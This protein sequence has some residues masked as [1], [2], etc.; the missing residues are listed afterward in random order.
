MKALSA[1]YVLPLTCMSYRNSLHF[2]DLILP[3]TLSSVKP[4]KWDLSK[5]NAF[6]I[7]RLA[8]CV[9]R[10]TSKQPD[11]QLYA[12]L[13]LCECHILGNPP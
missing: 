4:S 12:A 5:I 2:M 1:R 11:I 9:Q 3:N 7:Y 10:L 8:E 6:M 13:A